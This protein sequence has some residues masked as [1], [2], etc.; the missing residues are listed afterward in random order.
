MRKFFLIL[1]F[2]SIVVSCNK[3][4]V[5]NKTI[6]EEKLIVKDTLPKKIKEVVEIPEIIFTVQ[7][8]ALKNDNTS[9]NSIEN[10]QIFKENY[11]TK[12]RLGKFSTYKEARTYRTSILHKY[13]DA[14]VQALKKDAPI[15][16]KAALK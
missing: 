16:I 8:A 10:I 11:L 5:K 4:E 15:N 7:I 6:K 14:F 12:Y 1:I 3:K 9:F 2:A 13:P